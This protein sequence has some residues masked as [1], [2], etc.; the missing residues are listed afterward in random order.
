MNWKG[1][2][3]TVW[4]LLLVIVL[5]L[6]FGY[7]LENRARPAN[8]VWSRGDFSDTKTSVVDSNTE[9][10]IFNSEE[11]NTVITCAI[12]GMTFGNNI[13]RILWKKGVMTFE[14]NA[15][16]SARIFFEEFLKPYIDDYIKS[17]L[18]E[19]IELTIEVP[20]AI[21]YVFD[22]SFDY[23]TYQPVWF[24]KVISTDMSKCLIDN[25]LRINLNGKIYWVRLEVD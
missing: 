8:M 3:T 7:W 6:A 17:E 5:L 10:F 12:A 9:V 1:K 2:L 23:E 22:T 24:L 4:I 13:G 11:G 25:R 15:D 18:E 19:E 20:E 16:E 14:G 21:M